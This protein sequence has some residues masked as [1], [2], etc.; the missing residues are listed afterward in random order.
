M[1]PVR[2]RVVKASFFKA[3]LKAVSKRVIKAVIRSKY[4]ERLF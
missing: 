2:T 3:N 1:I 4:D